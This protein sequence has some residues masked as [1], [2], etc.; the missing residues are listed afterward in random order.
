M[1]FKPLRSDAL[2]RAPV[3]KSQCTKY[4]FGSEI[5]SVLF[6]IGR[7]LPL[8][9]SSPQSSPLHSETRSPHRSS[10][11]TATVLIRQTQAV[12][13]TEQSVPHGDRADEGHSFQKKGKN[14][15]G[16]VVQRGGRS[17]V[18]FFFCLNPVM[19]PETGKSVF[20]LQSD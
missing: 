1:F 18:F 12:N 15:G 6:S 10:V 13:R 2:F 16:G 9:V 14:G 11:K 19:E 7:T 5:V 8:P 3:S 4:I 17:R 20:L